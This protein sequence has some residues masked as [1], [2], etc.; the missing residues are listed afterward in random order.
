[1]K[2]EMHCFNKNNCGLSAMVLVL[3]N[4]TKKNTSWSTREDVTPQSLIFH[5]LWLWFLPIDEGKDGGDDSL[6]LFCSMLSP[7]T[8]GKGEDERCKNLLSG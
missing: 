1:M 2:E 3:Q 7:K 6:S 4:N 8:H 5:T